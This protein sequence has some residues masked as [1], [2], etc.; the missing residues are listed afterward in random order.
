MIRGPRVAMETPMTEP[1]LILHVP[2]D[3]ART[4]SLLERT[5]HVTAL[6][7]DGITVRVPASLSLMSPGV[8]LDSADV[9]ASLSPLSDLN[10]GM[11]NLVQA[12]IDDPRD[13]FDDP[14]WDQVARNWGVLAAEAQASGFQG[15]LFDN[16]EYFGEWD[17]FPEDYP[18]GDAARGL[19]AYRAK[20]SE[21]GAQMME[22]VMGAF[23]GAE[24]VVSMGPYHSVPATTD[25]P[26]AIE[27]QAGD[28]DLHEL[29]G[30]FFTGMLEGLGPE[31][32]LVSGGKLYQ[33]RTVE[34]FA[35]SRDYR[36][37]LDGRIDWEAPLERWDEVAQGHIVYAGE[38]P[39]G[40]DQTPRTLTDTLVNAI[41]RSEETVVLFSEEDDLDWLVEG[42]APEAW[43]DALAGARSGAS[44]GPDVVE[45][46][47]EADALFGASGDDRLT[48]APGDD[49]L[50]GGRGVDRIWGGRGDDTLSGGRGGDRLWGGIGDDMLTGDIGTD[51]LRGGA[52]RDTLD[53][54]GSRDLLDGGSGD[55]VLTGGQGRDT[56]VLSADGGVDRVLDF[57]LGRDAIRVR[58]GEARV[59]EGAEGAAVVLGDAALI[60]EGVS[61]SDALMLL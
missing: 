46:V 31:G 33:L 22:A 36:D 21:R 35:A 6:P 32:T 58:G 45:G 47:L 9:R 26:S 57:Q 54:G 14:A 5:E 52:G 38:F 34:E 40:F 13:L 24:V 16:E 49:V 2:D 25:A 10:A 50:G 37:G 55:D 29:R 20:A 44:F 8:A 51:A 27:A 60:L 23:P 30:P 17:D 28:W 1:K 53:G 11:E 12:V 43:I 7:V 18:P 61:P 59:E 19:D 56:F 4:Q 39:E 3:T 48:G 42:G 15:I 41:D